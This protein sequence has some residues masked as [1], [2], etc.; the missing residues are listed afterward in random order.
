M[1]ALKP[2]LKYLMLKTP[3]R[4]EKIKLAMRKSK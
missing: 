1:K 4:K 3:R 2:A